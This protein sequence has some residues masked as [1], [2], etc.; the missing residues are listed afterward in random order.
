MCWGSVA[1]CSV[2]TPKL[3][4]TYESELHVWLG[5]LPVFD[6]VIDIGAAEGWYAVGFLHRR[7]AQKVVAFEMAE[8]GRKNLLAN[9]RRNAVPPDRIEIR[10][11]C[12]V[13]GLQTLLSSLPADPDFRLLI[14]S[15]CE[16]FEGKLL[17]IQTLKLC[18][19]AFFLIETHDYFVPGVRAGLAKALAMT[20]AVAD[21]RP[22]RRRR[23]DISPNVPWLFRLPIISRLLMSERRCPDIGWLVATPKG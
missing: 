14:I 4:G 5:Q 22:T 9:V 3:L 10:G 7:L 23:Q 13:A 20:H 8:A 19:N 1:N 6:L 12:T 16:G 17:D 2:L 15:D 21:L 18:P 11:E